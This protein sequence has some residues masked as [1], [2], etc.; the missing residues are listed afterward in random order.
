MKKNSFYFVLFIT[1]LTIQ[2]CKKLDELAIVNTSEI[3]DISEYSVVAGGNISVSGGSE[4][5]ARGLCWSINASPSINDS[6]LFIGKGMGSYTDTIKGLLPNSIYY[7]RAFATNVNGTSYGEVKKI[8]TIIGNAALT[9]SPISNISS[10]SAISG[11]NIISD[12]GATVTARGICWSTNNNPTINDS[13]TSD[14]TG[15]GG[16]VS[17]LT[18]LS[19][20][21]QY[22]VRAYAINSKGVSYGNTITFS[23]ISNKPTIKTELATNIKSGSFD[24][25]GNVLSDGGFNVTARGVCWS[26]TNTMPTIADS[27]TTD[28]SGLGN[29]ISKVKNITYKTTYYVRAYATNVNGTSYGDT[30]MINTAQ[31]AIGDEYLGG[32]V[33]YF[34]KPG[35][36]GYSA[37]VLH[38]LILSLD[39]FSSPWGCA[40]KNISGTNENIGYGQANTSLIVSQCTQTNSAAYICDRLVSG[41]YS[42]WYLPSRFELTEIGRNYSVLNLKSGTGAYYWCSN[43]VNNNFGTAILVVPVLVGSS[44]APSAKSDSRIFRAVRSF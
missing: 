18:N 8:T 13:K 16:F 21:T 24:C 4:I 1:L 14:G 40:T 27:K 5:I 15:I 28:G 22:Y 7:L 10:G 35:D 26:S 25:G 19:F 38:G 41:G 29:F 34:L 39:S 20:S 36:P 43:Q 12:G 44:Y 42:D 3:S 6:V 2:S 11:G 30:L 31:L 37:T 9:T 23:T 33:A 17:N 32:L